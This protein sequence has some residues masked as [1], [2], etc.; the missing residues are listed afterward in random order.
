MKAQVPHEMQASFE[1]LG[2]AGIQIRGESPGTPWDAL[3]RGFYMRLLL[4]RLE[5]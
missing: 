1:K 2:Q 5:Q 3:D 4:V